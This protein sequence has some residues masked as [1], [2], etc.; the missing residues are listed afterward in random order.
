MS[1]VKRILGLHTV[2]QELVARISSVAYPDTV[3]C[4]V[5]LLDRHPSNIR[6]IVVE[7]ADTAGLLTAHRMVYCLGTNTT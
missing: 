6:R 5:K 4:P 1:R 7:D 2:V 3:P